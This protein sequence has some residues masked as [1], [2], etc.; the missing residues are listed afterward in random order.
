MHGIVITAGRSFSLAVV[1]SGFATPFVF[2]KR[3]SEV[4]L[5]M[6]LSRCKQER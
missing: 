4:H 3:Y 6:V 2:V 5:S 1:D